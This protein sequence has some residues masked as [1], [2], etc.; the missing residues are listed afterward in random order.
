M[1]VFPKGYKNECVDKFSYIIGLSDSLHFH[2]MGIKDF[3]HKTPSEKA[4][5]E[6]WT[7][8]DIS[9]DNSYERIVDEFFKFDKKNRLLFIQTGAKLGIDFCIKKLKL[10]EKEKTI[11]VLE[12]KKQIILQGAPGTGKTSTSAEIALSIVNNSVKNYSSREELI[13]EYKKAVDE[14]YITF[15]TFHQ[16]LDYEEFIE[17]LNP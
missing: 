8:I 10:M 5:K 4:S 15:T 9:I 6:S 2:M 1:K 13:K 7:E 17:G 14:G 3:Q 16:S 11:K 12:H